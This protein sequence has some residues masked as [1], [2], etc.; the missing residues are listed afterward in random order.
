MAQKSAACT[1]P[2]FSKLSDAPRH[3]FLHADTLRVL[4]GAHSTT[5]AHIFRLLWIAVRTV[6]HSAPLRFGSARSVRLA[7]LM[8]GWKKHRALRHPGL[9]SA[10]GLQHMRTIRHCVNGSGVGRRTAASAAHRLG[11][12]ASGLEAKLAKKPPSSR[13]APLSPLLRDSHPCGAGCA[14]RPGS[15][16][17]FH[18]VRFWDRVS[19]LCSARA[20]ERQGRYCGLKAKPADMKNGEMRSA[21]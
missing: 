7:R 4:T 21:A 15:S 18:H 8:A 5:Y 3:A 2:A 1:T 12:A 19:L 6:C 20:G 13:T 17:R 14:S 16:R 11:V 10:R 9:P